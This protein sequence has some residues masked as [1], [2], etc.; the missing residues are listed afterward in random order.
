MNRAFRASYDEVESKYVNFEHRNG[1]IVQQNLTALL[2]EH[3]SISGK[4]ST[5]GY[6]NCKDDFSAL[7]TKNGS[8]CFFI[9][10]R[11][12]AGE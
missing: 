5:E 7:A 10:I 12:V 11:R 1:Q 8:K 4:S 2:E 9:L 6:I 3:R